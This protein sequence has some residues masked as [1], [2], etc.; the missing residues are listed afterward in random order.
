LYDSNPTNPRHSAVDFARMLGLGDDRWSGLNGGYR[1]YFDPRPMLSQ[2]D[3]GTDIAAAW[4]GLW[5]G[6]HHQGDVGEASYA[7][8]PHLVRIHRQR[9]VI[10]WNTY[11]IVAIVELARNRGGNPQV[12]KWLEE[13]Y[14][15]AIQELAEIGSTEILRANASEEIRAILG[16]LAIAKGARTQ[17]RFLVMYSEEELLDMEARH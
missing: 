10:D 16:I 15:R 11:A 5:D 14:F 17:G 4:H 9:G 7:A 2:L 3:A 12:P 13:G 8:V 1:T 6:L